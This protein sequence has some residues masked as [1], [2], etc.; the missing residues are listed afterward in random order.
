MEYANTLVQNVLVDFLA[1]RCPLLL[2]HVKTPNLTLTFWLCHA[3]NVNLVDSTDWIQEAYR[4][5]L[6]KLW[7][8]YFY[9]LFHDNTQVKFTVLLVEEV[10]SYFYV[11]SYLTDIIPYSFQGAINTRRVGASCPRLRRNLA[12]PALPGC[13]R[14]ETCHDLPTSGYR[15]YVP[16]LQGYLQ[17]C[18]DGPCGL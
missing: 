11:S 14:W 17:H 3:I 13:L 5:C 15:S 6:M 16:K 18:V 4:C 7:A 10:K 1:A 2:S 12:V 8:S 9:I